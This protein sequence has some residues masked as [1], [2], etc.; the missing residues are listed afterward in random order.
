MNKLVI[1][2]II[3]V[4]LAAGIGI[5]FVFQKSMT[6][7]ESSAVPLSPKTSLAL[8]WVPIAGASWQI[9]FAS[10][11][12]KV[13]NDTDVYD[14]DMYDTPPEKINELHAARKKVICY[15]NAGAYE[16]WR[17]DSA[18]F[19]TTILG[20]NY[21]P[22]EKWLDIRRID[23]LSPILSKR[24]D[25]CATKGFDGI[26][27]D[28]INGFENDTGF[29]LTAEDQIKFNKWLASESHKRRLAVGL[30]NNSTQVTDLVEAFDFAITE[31][32]AVEGWCT[33]FQAFIDAGKPVF[34]IEYKDTIDSIKFQE[35]CKTYTPK[36][37]SMIF[38]NRELDAFAEYCAR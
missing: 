10:S 18:D 14:V 2:I 13:L 4:I 6:T 20:K 26:E 21:W 29:P 9:Q 35:L 5:F 8:R 34:A 22:G 27:F 32:C 30:K 28:N 25:F 33:D 19:P 23:L 17:V 36:K 37:Y 16:D 38:K 15:V 24:I 3:A 12:V 11:D 1:P 7:P 31:S